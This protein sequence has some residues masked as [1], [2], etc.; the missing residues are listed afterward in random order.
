ME[1]DQSSFGQLRELAQDGKVLIGVHTAGAAAFL[2]KTAEEME[3]AIG[4]S[5]SFEPNIVVLLLYASSLMIFVSIPLAIRAFGWWGIPSIVA[6]FG[7]LAFR[8][9]YSQLGDQRI[10][11]TIFFTGLAAIAVMGLRLEM[12]TK[13]WIFSVV[14]A[15][16]FTK[17]RFYAAQHLLRSLVVRNY[18]AFAMLYGSVIFVKEAERL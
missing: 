4:E 2:D 12:W 18:R 8:Y 1:I 14:L 6:S 9:T 5:V 11:T 15:I 17:L 10:W 16:L 13:L 3:E 7:V